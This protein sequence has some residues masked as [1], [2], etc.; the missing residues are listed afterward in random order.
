MNL[1][2]TH[3]LRADTQVSDTVGLDAQLR[4]FW[5]PES[6]GIYKEERSVYED[7]TSNITFQDGWYKVS[8]P[9]MEF[10]RPLPDNYQLSVKRLQGLLRR[11]NQDPQILREY[12]STIKEQ[13][14]KGIIESV[15]MDEPCA[16]RVHC[17]PH[18]AVIRRDKTTTKLHIVYDASAKSDGPSERVSAQ[19]SKL[20]STNPRP[21]ATLPILQNRLNSRHRKG[22]PY[23]RSH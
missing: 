10:Q 9:W 6:L 19:R 17:L 4:S 16:N 23:D 14:E 21:V 7:F 12:D 3:V 18:H 20:Q 1:T 5:E 8:L 11:L 13:L 15:S 22:L 2:T